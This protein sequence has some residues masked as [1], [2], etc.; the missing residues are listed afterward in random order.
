MSRREP[1]GVMAALGAAL[2]LTLSAPDAAAHGGIPRA[3]E[4]LSEPGNAEHML[5]RSYLWGF[6]DSRDGGE[7]WQYT[8]AEAYSGRSTSAQTRSIAM[9]PGGRILV[10]NY[11]EGLHLTDDGC[12]WR[13]H[14]AF[15]EEMIT[16]VRLDPHVQGRLYLSSTLKNGTGFDSK[17]LRSDDRGDT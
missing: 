14:P 7:T 8:C 5:L 12:N 1:V 6:F 2:A 17:L 13:K 11:F 10:A 3:Y 16:D 15:P 4:I 9:V